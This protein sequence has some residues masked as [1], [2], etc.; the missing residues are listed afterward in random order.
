MDIGGGVGVGV[1]DGVG[2]SVS[3][4]GNADG[5]AN[6]GSDEVAVA[7]ATNT[8]VA[9]ARALGILTTA[10]G[11]TPNGPL[12]FILATPHP[13]RINIKAT[14]NKNARRIS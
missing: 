10:L 5:T 1:E 7:V 11:I 9:E 2:V 8:V 3:V 6:V 12:S 4:G 14:T 13:L